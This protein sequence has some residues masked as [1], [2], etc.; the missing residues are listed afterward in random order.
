MIRYLNATDSEELNNYNIQK[1]YSRCKSDRE[2]LSTRQSWKIRI[3]NTIIDYDDENNQLI[4]D[5]HILP[6][7][8]SD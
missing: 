8:L 6:C 5:G 4:H 1:S 7:Y 2:H 3:V